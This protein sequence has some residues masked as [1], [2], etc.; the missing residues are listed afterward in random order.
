M[1]FA[2]ALDIETTVKPWFGRKASPFHPDNWIV[3][4]A[5]VPA[6]KEARPAVHGKYWTTTAGSDGWLVPIM[7]AGTA[8]PLRFMAGF[9][10]KFDL[11]HLLRCP[12]NYRAWQQWVADGGLVWDCQLAE[13]LLHGMTQDNQTLALEDVSLRYGGT[14]KHDAVK[15]LW[16]AGV[17]TPDIPKELLMRYLCG[18]LPD[19]DEPDRI[20]GDALN[21]VNIFKAQYLAATKR[22]MLPLMKANMGALIAT[23]EMERNGLHVDKEKGL[24]LAEEL[25]RDIVVLED[26]L[27][28]FI[29]EDLPFPFNWNSTRQ[30]SALIFGGQITYPRREYDLADGTQ[31][32]AAPREDAVDPLYLYAQ[33]DETHAVLSDGSTCPVDL[34]GDYIRAGGPQPVFY[35]SGLRA[36]EAKTKKVHVPDHTKPKT[37]MVE[38]TYLFPRQVQPKKSWE[39]AEPGTYS[40]AAEVIEELALE[41]ALPFLQALDTLTKATKDLG[42]YYLVTGEDGKQKGMLTKVQQDG[43]IHHSLHLV[44]TVT[45]RL[46]SADPNLQNIPRAQQQI[47]KYASKVKQMFT[48]RYKDGQS[49]SS[50]F[51]SLE[52]YCQAYLTGD[53]QLIADLKAGL[54]M[55][56]ARLS[57]VENLAYE[58]VLVLCKGKDAKP[59]WEAKRTHIK[60]FSFQRAYGAGGA[61]IAAFLKVC[62]DAVQE[63]IKADEKRYPGVKAWQEAA[64]ASVKESKK[65][66][67]RFVLH[68]I[69]KD[70]VRVWRGTYTDIL[71]KTYVF[72][73][74]P[75][76]EFA[77]K[78]DGQLMGFKPTEIKNYPMQGLGG[79]IMKVAMWLAVRAFYKVRNFGGLALLVNTVHDA[80]YADADPSVLAKASGL[81]HACMSEATGY[82]ENLFSLKLP[83]PVPSETTAG[84]SMADEGRI[85]GLDE[86]AERARRWVRSTFFDN[87][88][89]SWERN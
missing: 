21:T 12:E 9:N 11:L 87:Y 72:D 86:Q 40:T 28:Q 35:K 4:A 15:D 41:N 59:E 7:G 85:E 71:G 58:D 45:A 37:R 39:G 19:Y 5:Y 89:P 3:A 26:G 75:A 79:E 16:N 17:D 67:G 60:V 10:I 27:A 24:A 78:R 70:N 82:M 77:F 38:D 43:M 36:G 31:T 68:P 34:I 54:D 18:D 73:E 84:L 44:R 80:L 1:P 52:I 22:G 69:T 55:H 61:K 53:K 14:L 46:S 57:T 30:K 51:T 76:P 88:I 6:T 2:V 33:K 62:I 64:L 74:V 50:D 42:T 48:S 20:D 83:L 63:W 8:D 56:C 29:P 66:T 81:L 23:I 13:Y 49:V 32:W 47:G 65:P 25:A